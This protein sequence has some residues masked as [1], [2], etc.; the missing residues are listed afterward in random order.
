M[1]EKNCKSSIMH[2]YYLILNSTH[3]SRNKRDRSKL[4]MNINIVVFISGFLL[5][6]IYLSSLD[7]TVVTSVDVSTYL[8]LLSI[9]Q[10][11]S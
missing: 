4:Y 11:F 2:I 6:S 9:F 7:L 1:F 5:F 8:I 10:K 3:A